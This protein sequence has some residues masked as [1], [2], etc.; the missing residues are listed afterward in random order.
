MCYGIGVDLVRTET[1]CCASSYLPSSVNLVQYFLIFK[2]KSSSYIILVIHD[3]EA[4]KMLHHA[5]YV[6]KC[7]LIIIMKGTKVQTLG[8]RTVAGAWLVDWAIMAMGAI[9]KTHAHR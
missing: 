8:G 4:H 6:C 3:I 9:I 2:K 7:V 1:S 5:T